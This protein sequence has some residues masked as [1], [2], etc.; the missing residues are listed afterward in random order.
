MANSLL[1][2]VMS[3]VRD[4]DAAAQYAA[5]PAQ[6]IADANLTDVTSVDVNHLIPVVA[7]SLSS[8]VPTGGVGGFADAP[9]TGA[10]RVGQRC[11]HRGVRRVR[12]PPARSRAIDVVADH[13]PIVANV[14][15][16][17]GR[18]RRRR[19]VDPGCDVPTVAGVDGSGVGDL[20][21]PVIDDVPVVDDVA[22]DL[23]WRR[24]TARR[25]ARPPSD[26]P[27]DPGFDLFT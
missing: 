26:H 23:G 12:R 1:D 17:S 20:D 14:I 19:V 15:E 16:P 27:H 21:A 5:N 13:V 7:E 4:P 9:T 3:V 25:S 10:Q 22:V 11:G 24:T 8:A 6:A 18:R 2:F